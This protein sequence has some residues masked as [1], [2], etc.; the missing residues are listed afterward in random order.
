[1]EIKKGIKVSPGF[2]ISTAFVLDSEE[3][4][5]QQRFIDKERVDSEVHRFERA[6]VEACKEIRLIQQQVDSGAGSEYV[7]LR[8]SPA[9]S[10]KSL[11]KIWTMIKA[12]TAAASSQVS[13]RQTWPYIAAGAM[14]VISVQRMA[15]KG[16]FSPGM[17]FQP[18][19]RPRQGSQRSV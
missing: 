13:A 4:R 2:A 14:T 1:M 3:F 10:R 9:W 12:Q 11:S 7:P 5:I 18:R 6:V 19:R 8:R 16:I 17:C 15:T